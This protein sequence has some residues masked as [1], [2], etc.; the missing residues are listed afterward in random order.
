VALQGTIRDFAL[1]D[2]F[3]LIG[4][5][6]KTGVLTLQNDTDTV[7]LK[8]LEGQIVGADTSTESL[9]DRLGELL[10]RTGRITDVQL[11]GALRIQ[12][13]TLRRLGNILV[14]RDF[15]DEDEL[16]EALRVQ[17][18]QI[19]YRLFRWQNGRY[20]FTASD[21][22]DYDENHFTPISSETVLMEGARMMDEWPIIERRIRSDRVILR[23]TEAGRA[24]DL[25]NVAEVEDDLDFDLRFDVDRQEDDAEKTPEPE[26]EDDDRISVEEREVIAKVDGR[27]TV[28]G[29]CDIVTLGE[30]DTC[31]ILSDLI[32]RGL[33]EE[34]GTE[35]VKPSRGREVAGTMLGWSVLAGIVILAALS[36][37][38]LPSNPWTPWRAV[39]GDE[40]TDRMREY[41]S[42]ARLEKLEGAIKVFYLDAGT[43]PGSLEVL[44]V[45]G[46][47]REGD[48]SDP[49]GR[50]YGFEVSRGGYRL[51]GLDA[52]GENRPDLTIARR[53]TPVQQML[54]ADD[55]GG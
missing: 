23:L 25:D 40:A 13:Q 35:A 24:L 27:R 4:I 32:T 55:T 22:L 15:I 1:P 50:P 44:S 52:A 26:D 28:R 18:S 34:T 33:L 46:Y 47:V 10:V 31:R 5:Q 51:M 39:A 9:E 45:G 42:V 37:A 7:S 54:M 11:Q 53:F 3:Q 36:L 48:L 43:I 49:W 30:F 12:K 21:N 20:R 38:T 14:E 6:R 17:S 16:I 8:F 41:A 2:I 29:I 19:I